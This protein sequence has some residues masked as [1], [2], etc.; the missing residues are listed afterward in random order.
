MNFTCC[1]LTRKPTQPTRV[2]HVASVLDDSSRSMTMSNEE[3]E[4]YQM[5]NQ[6]QA[7]QMMPSSSTT[8]LAQI[9]NSIICFTS[10]APSACVIDSGS[11]DHMNWERYLLY[12][13]F[14]ILTTFCNVSRWFYIL[15]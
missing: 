5:F 13:D 7:I 15:H 9:G 11:S 8:T 10:T 1:R 6:F 14:D 4:R 12:F 3:F 2:A